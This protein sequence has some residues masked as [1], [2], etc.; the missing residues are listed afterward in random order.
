MPRTER[1]SQAGKE[2]KENNT[3]QNKKLETNGQALLDLVFC[4][5]AL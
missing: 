4:F 2:E 5:G 1:F 3:N